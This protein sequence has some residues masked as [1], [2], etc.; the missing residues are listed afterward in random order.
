VRRTIALLVAVCAVFLCPVAS[1]SAATIVVNTTAPEAAGACGLASAIKAANLDLAQQSC[2]AGNGAD[3]IEF[4]LPSPSTITLA[5][6]LPAITTAVEIA[7]PGAGALTI[8][9]NHAVRPLG[10]GFT[11]E[12]VTISNLTIADGKSKFGG[13]MTNSAELLRLIGVVVRGN[14]AVEEGGTDVFPAGGAI[15]NQGKL[16]VIASTIAE[17]VARGGGA[18]NQNSPSGGAV[19]SG[20]SSELVLEDSTLSGNRTIATGTGGA[21]TSLSQGG[22]ILNFGVVRIVRSTINGNT[23]TAT[24]GGTNNTARGG[25][26][27]NANSGS[28]KVTIER[29]TIAGN[30]ASGASQASGGGVYAYGS[31]FQILGSTIAANGATE[32]ANVS[33]NVPTKFRD[34]ILAAPVGGPSCVGSFIE[35]LGFNLD[36]GNSCGFAKPSDQHGVNPLLGPLAANGGPTATMALLHGSPAIDRG[37]SVAGEATDQR[38]FARPVEIAAVANGPESNGADVGAYEAQVIRA[39]ITAGPR[40]GETIADPEPTFA[41]ATPEPG[42]TFACSFDGAVPAACTSP[43]RAPRLADGPHTLSIVATGQSGYAQE[44]PTTRAFTVDTRRPAPLPAPK[45]AVRPQSR[46]HHLPAETTKRRLKIRFSSTVVGSSFRCKLDKAKWRGCRS[47]YKTPQLSLGKHVFKL[48]AIGPTGLA[49]KTPAVKKFEVVVPKH[50]GH[51]R[52]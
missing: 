51:R 29:S 14:E 35:S 39:E 2:A 41:F 18:S 48:K 15:Y 42:A 37:T 38:G 46:I 45:P 47:P 3:R 44:V 52:G 49:D 7:G 17:N 27:N 34:T 1:A 21:S 4:A 8:S 30:S 10:V 25:A 50:H 12:T 24:G 32:G 6:E 36:E 22:A 28:V 20:S 5:A 23:A 16:Q 40:E 19:Y 13:A 31:S 33:I 9:G 26:M 43:L 11:T